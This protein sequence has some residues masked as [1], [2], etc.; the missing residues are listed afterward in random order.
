MN[1]VVISERSGFFS[2]FLLIVF[3]SWLVHKVDEVHCIQA[4]SCLKGCLAL[5]I[6]NKIHE[7]FMHRTHYG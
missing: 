1:N 4:D 3:T 7:W 6:V 5:A 2:L